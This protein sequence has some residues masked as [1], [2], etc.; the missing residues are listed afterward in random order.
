[1]PFDIRKVAP[2][3]RSH[4]LHK[5]QGGAQGKE[6]IKEYRSKKGSLTA[7]KDDRAIRRIFRVRRF[8]TPP[9]SFDEGR[10]LLVS[11]RPTMRIRTVPW[12][13]WRLWII[14][15]TCW[16]LQVLPNRFGSVLHHSVLLLTR[17]VILITWPK[18]DDAVQADDPDAYF[19]EVVEGIYSEINK[20]NKDMLELEDIIAMTATSMKLQDILNDVSER[21]EES[22]RAEMFKKYVC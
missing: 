1:M 16:Q 17:S 6:L 14:C 5:T 12:I 4:R 11:Y 10:T 7:S 13:K 9:F 19:E 21:L 2:V 22:W 15:E 20:K 8:S 3:L 18:Q